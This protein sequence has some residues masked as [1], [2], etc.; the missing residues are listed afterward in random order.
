MPMFSNITTD[1]K[2]V[3]T[4]GKLNKTVDMLS[5]VRHCIKDLSVTSGLMPL[6]LRLMI[7]KWKMKIFDFS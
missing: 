6:T 5:S 2:P 3:T 1:K 4:S 7:S